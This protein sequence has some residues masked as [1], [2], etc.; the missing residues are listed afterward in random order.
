MWYRRAAEQGLAQAQLNLGVMYDEGYGVPQN[1]V[2]A[3]MWY[4]RAAEQGLAQAQIILGINYGLGR[5][6]PQ[7][8]VRAHMWFNLAAS[9]SAADTDARER[10]LKARNL[11]TQRLSPEELARARRMAH[12]WQP[13]GETQSPPQTAGADGDTQ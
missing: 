4:R 3:A 1:Y 9:S 7:D 13:R 11:V 2:E 10:A 12:E 6:V 5:G 8:S